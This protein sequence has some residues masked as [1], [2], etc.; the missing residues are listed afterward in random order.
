MPSVRVSPPTLRRAGPSDAPLLARLAATTFADTFAADND[1]RDMAAYA[2]I[3]FG[4][5]IQRR[6]LLD[7]RNTVL[8]A[9]RGDEVVGYAMLRRDAAPACV[10]PGESVEVARLYAV[11]DAIGSGVGAAL[12]QGCL[13][14]AAAQQ[15]ETLW[16]GVWE[17]NVRAIAF[18]RRWG[19]RDVGSQGFPLGT[20]L[21]TDR[22]M[23]RRV[24]EGA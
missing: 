19:F 17:Q 1:P 3:A 15:H 8:L 13:E 24:A 16:L 21:Q 22:V 2:S 4:D 14:E 23:V 12:M 11:Q 18:Y 20:D 5:D 10:A 9:A 6:E 7:P